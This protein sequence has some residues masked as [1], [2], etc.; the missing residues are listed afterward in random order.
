M[1]VEMEALLCLLILIP[2]RI[3]E[4]N[5]ILLF[6]FIVHHPVLVSRDFDIPVRGTKLCQIY[7]SVLFF[8][9]TICFF[10]D[11]DR[12]FKFALVALIFYS[13]SS[14]YYFQT[15]SDIQFKVIIN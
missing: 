2:G 7:F 12:C 9:K 11:V 8:K 5:L 15:F 14:Y 13:N 4:R 1:V 6:T 10:L 3:V